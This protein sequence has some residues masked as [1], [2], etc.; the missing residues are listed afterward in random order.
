MKREKFVNVVTCHCWYEVEISLFA[1]NENFR[2]IKWFCSHEISMESFV[3][4]SIFGKIATNNFLMVY[5]FESQ[6][7][8]LWKVNLHE[9]LVLIIVQFWDMSLGMLRSIKIMR[10]DTRPP[11]N[12]SV[13]FRTFSLQILISFRLLVVAF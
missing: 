4:K 12:F 11:R 13:S 10:L 1:E 2:I 9:I 8:C 7:A 5:Q 3:W 6:G